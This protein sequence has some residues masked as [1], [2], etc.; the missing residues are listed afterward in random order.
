MDWND[1]DYDVNLEVLE[2]RIDELALKDKELSITLLGIMRYVE[3]TEEFAGGY[4]DE[5][6]MEAKAYYLGRSR[7]W[8]Q[9]VRDEIDRMA[10]DVPEVRA[11]NKKMDATFALHDK[12]ID[13][14]FIRSYRREDDERKTPPV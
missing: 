10:E 13:H 9:E 6:L 2:D 5:K 11:L 12:L 7:K 4:A 3:H 14:L 8:R 1:L